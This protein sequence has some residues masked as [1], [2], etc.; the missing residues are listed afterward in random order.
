MN[1]FN[2][3]FKEVLIKIEPPYETTKFIDNS[4]NDFL[5]KVNKR[6]KSL[7]IDAEVFIGGSFAKKTVIKK[8][9]YDVDVFMR[10]DK[11][12]KGKN[13]SELTSKLL[14]GIK[15]ILIIH[16]SRDYFRI[17]FS[18]DFFIEVIPVL[19]VKNPKESDNITDLSYS[20]VKYINK[21]IKSKKILEDIK[22]AKAFC[23]ANNCYGAESYIGG[24]SG[25]SLE[26]LVYH[27]KSFLKFLKEIIKAKDKIII[28]TERH[29]RN[30][31]IILMDINS[32]KLISPIILIDPT[33]K[34]RNA[35]AALSDETFNKFKKSA[36]QFL[37][38][39][40]IKSFEIQKTDLEKI[41]NSALKNKN[42][43]ILIEAYTNKQEGDV[44]GS[45]LLKFY[46]HLNLEMEKYFEIKNSGFNYN[47]KH[48]AR[49]FFVVKNKKEILHNGPNIK[50]KL[51]VKKFKKEHKKTFTKLKK[52][53]AKEKI[54]FTVIEFIKKF[55][56]KNK[57]RIKEMYIKELKILD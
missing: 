21:K 38:N 46:R 45:K 36:K 18:P 28:D 32:A 41:K 37:K 42:K 48:S 8:D 30:K 4:L 2:N 39:P 20:H 31:N 43:F 34:Q 17:Q 47:H 14:E 50:D 56:V 53:Y 26:L 25:Y 40:T 19:K 9:Y 16:G 15:N 12:Y 35:L 33:Y 5:K 22:I 57:K 24:F 7:K 27:Y 52:L 1:K 23:H 51:N 10:F 11:K 49:Y 3:I 55:K 6:I 29:Y 44:A 13:L 54:D